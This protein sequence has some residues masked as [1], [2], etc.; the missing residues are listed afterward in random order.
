MTRRP[1]KDDYIGMIAHKTE[2]FWTPNWFKPAKPYGV[3]LAD[4]STWPDRF[5]EFLFATGNYHLGG[6]YQ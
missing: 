4:T 2:R 3:A 5:D 6:K 1:T